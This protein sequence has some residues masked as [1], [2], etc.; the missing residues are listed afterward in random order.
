MTTAR[1]DAVERLL[2]LRNNLQDAWVTF[3]R[4]TLESFEAVFTRIYGENKTILEVGSGFGMTCIL[5]GLL[6]AKEAH[7]VELVNRAVA[8]ANEMRDSI[9]PRLPVFFKQGDAA[10]WLPYP[11]AKFDVLLLVEAISHIIVADLRAFLA[12]MSRVVK[13]GG[14]IYISD[15]NNERS[16]YRRKINREIW[17]RFENGPPTASG[18][19]VHTHSVKKAYVDARREIAERTVAGLSASAYE[20]IARNTFCFTSQE[21]EEATRNYAANGVLPSAPYRKGICAIDP[22][23]NMYIEK[24]FDPFELCS[25][26]REMGFV[27]DIIST[28]RKLPMQKLWDAFPRL[29]M[30]ISNG[31][32][33]SARKLQ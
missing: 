14:I 11:G 19:T 30:L 13:P 27:I 18:E 6:G 8:K 9:D 33:I 28:R 22:V 31:F 12:E 7:G 24:M 20:D 32:V 26:F 29:T 17:D 16:A 2:K 10:K 21:V 15:G 4:S 1:P 25:I 5:F 3:D 23:T